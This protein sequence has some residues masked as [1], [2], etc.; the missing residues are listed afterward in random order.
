MM[1][2]M[3]RPAD[4]KNADDQ[5]SD[6]TILGV[7]FPLMEQAF[8]VTRTVGGSLKLRTSPLHQS[9]IEDKEMFTCIFPTLAFSAWPS[10]Y[11]WVQPIKDCDDQHYSVLILPWMSLIY[12]RA[13][14]TQRLNTGTYNYRK[15][16]LVGAF[17][18]E[19]KCM[20]DPSKRS[21]R[22]PE[23]HCQYVL[24]A[25]QKNPCVAHGQKDTVLRGYTIPSLTRTL[26][27]IWK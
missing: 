4:G 2:K 20:C 18:R 17:K 27:P 19:Q 22:T 14:V 26:F 23:V 5:N 11:T 1:T 6:R 16:W 25:K 13:L 12:F 3:A 8:P 7:E 9:H 24:L 10:L 15:P 21:S